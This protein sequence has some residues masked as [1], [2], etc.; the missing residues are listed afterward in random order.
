MSD[1]PALGF[2][3]TQFVRSAGELLATYR[4]L[5]ACA[6][7]HGFQLTNVYVQTLGPPSAVFDLLG[8][9]LES[10]GLPLVVPTLHHLAALGDPVQIRDHLRRIDHEVLIAIKQAERTC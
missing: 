3:S 10:D 9:L 5:D 8:S 4:E 6:T 7:V 1:M 2:I